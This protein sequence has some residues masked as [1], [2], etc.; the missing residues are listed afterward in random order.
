MHNIPVPTL[1]STQSI[2]DYIKMATSYC[3]VGMSMFVIR[4]TQN[5]HIHCV[6]EC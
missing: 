4:T 1:Q 5:T 6:Y 3:C 2:Y